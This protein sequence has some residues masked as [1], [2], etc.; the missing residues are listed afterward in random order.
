MAELLEAVKTV[1][2]PVTLVLWFVYQGTNREKS[3]DEKFTSLE[4]F[5]REELL[6]T[7]KE[8]TIMN[9][10]C[11]ISIEDT[12]RI[13]CEHKEVIDKNTDALIKNAVVLDKCLGS[14]EKANHG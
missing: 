10:K 7:S 4:T 13:L 2:V 12:N 14:L 8:A 1:G 5:C 6:T 11:A 3:Q 9:S